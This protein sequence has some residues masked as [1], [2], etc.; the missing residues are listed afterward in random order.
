MARWAQMRRWDLFAA[1]M[2]QVHL[3][4]GNKKARLRDFHPEMM[5]LS[6]RKKRVISF[7]R[8]CRMMVQ[9]WKR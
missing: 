5:P 9:H 3:A 4:Q 1:L 7:D 6:G 2:L 8:F